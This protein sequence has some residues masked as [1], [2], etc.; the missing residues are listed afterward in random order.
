M[1][2]HTTTPA[3][4]DTAEARRP[5]S[6][7]TRRTFSLHD[8]HLMWIVQS[9]EIDLFVVR[10]ATDGRPHA[11]R[12]LMRVAPGQ[13]LFGIADNLAAD[14][15][16]IARQSPGTQLEPRLIPASAPALTSVA[17]ADRFVELLGQW[18]T[19]LSR[20]AAGGLVPKEAAVLAANTRADT[21]EDARLLTVKDPLIWVQQ[22]A[23]SSRFL[24]RDFATIAG[25]GTL[26]PLSPVAWIEL[27]AE[28][29]IEA[30]DARN[31]LW[32]GEFRQGLD[33]F[34]ETA[35]ACIA[36]TLDGVA[37]AERERLTNRTQADSKA[38]EGAIRDLASPL[39]GD[40]GDL[41]A[42]MSTSDTPLLRACQ[43]IGNLIGVTMK[44]HPDLLRGRVVK[45]PVAFIAK[46]S[47]VRYRRVALKDD[48]FKG[49]SEPLLVFGNDD[50]RPAALLPRRGRHRYLYFDPETG[51]TRPLDEETAAGLN[52]FGFMFYRPFPAV[53]MTPKELLA[54]GLKDCRRDLLMIAAMAVASGLLS[55]VLPIVT[56]EVFDSLIPGAR[57]PE[58]LTACAVIGVAAL[59]TALFNLTRG[60]AVL[61]LQGRLSATLQA[62]LWDRLLSLPVPFFREYAAGD[63]ANRSMAFSQIRTVLTGATLSA[64]LSGFASLSN[65]VL[66]FY[67]SPKLAIIAT[68]LTAIALT[69]TIAAGTGELR[70]QR[71]IST[72]AGRI[73]GIIVEFISGIAKFRVAG[74][75]HRAFVLWVKEFAKQKR[76]DYDARQISNWLAVFN[77]V[78]L[79]VCLAMLFFANSG[80]Q[81]WHDTSLST[82]EFLAFVAAF[83]QFMTST[84]LL[85]GAVVGVMNVVPLYERAV[86]ILHALPEVSSA[87]A[88]PPDLSGEIQAHH[89][90]FRYRSDS[91]LVLR[92]VSFHIKPGEYVAFVGPSGCGKSTLFRLMLGFETPESGALYYDAK[93]LS[94]IDVEGVRRQIGV[95]LQSG[96]LVAGSIKDN[97]CGA[98]WVAMEDVE[99][100]ARMAGLE[101]DI[102]NMPMGFH[103]MVQAGGGGLSGGQRQRVLIARAIVAKPRILMFDEATSALDNRTQ[104]I[105]SDSLK[106]LKATRVVIAH[107]LSTILEADRIY[108]MEAGRVVQSGTYT[109]LMAQP[110]LFRELASRQLT[111]DLE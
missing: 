44:P 9:G 50:N 26:F 89:L 53:A 90:V 25:G 33:A 29:E 96:M 63:L 52:P 30:V 21:H 56:G 58:L 23:G 84:L 104:A 57:R 14:V 16:L 13:A 99:E 93:E 110:G 76:T 108:V 66:L 19:N 6:L 34:H 31:G 43:A 103:T 83:S 94:G 102:K 47:G 10:G 106:S 98:A 37:A 107:R 4:S 105:V 109:E 1:Q 28:S 87:K 18:V 42:E 62:G 49:S 48:W 74:A 27:Q 51:H 40:R 17:E 20:A 5:F 45:N 15:R 86:P 70:L 36:R 78:F 22:R 72:N 2:T 92:D 7:P 12:P 95:V 35:L 81:S 61:R 69:V 97:I 59:A 65:F 82:G 39:S 101:D 111:E 8:R 3:T 55:M 88:A 38:V 75:E 46:A 11:L 79:T 64:I 41:H 80:I 54:F 85:G 91:P 32:Q 24:G 71:S 100:A 77:A 73:A 60:F 68:V 67:Y